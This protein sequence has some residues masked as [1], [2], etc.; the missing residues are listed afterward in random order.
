MITVRDLEDEDIEQLLVIENEAFSLPWS[1]DSFKEAIADKNARYIVVLDDDILCGYLGMWYGGDE[2]EITNVAIG[3]EHRG[4]GYS[5]HLLTEA[6]K[7]AREEGITKLFLEVRE[8]NTVA[9]SLYKGHGFTEIG[10]RKNFYVKP[11]EDGIVLK[12]NI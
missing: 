7:I 5:H 1:R 8:S 6:E 3:S 2:S 10:I 4:K 12:K 11:C 9:K